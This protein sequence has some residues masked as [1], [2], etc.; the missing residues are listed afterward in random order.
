MKITILYD[1]NCRPGFKASWGFS[2]LVETDKNTIIFDTGW[3][4]NILLHNLGLANVQLEKIDGVVLSH[5]HW[6]HIGGLNHILPLMRKPKVLLL[7]SFSQNLK[8]ELRT[9]TEVLEV[10][11][12]QMIVDGVWTTGE[13]G[14]QIK[15]QSLVVEIP[16]MEGEV[17]GKV[18]ITGCAHP[19]LKSII[20]TAQNV[21]KGDL[22]ALIGGL[23]DSRELGM[24]GKFELLVPCHCTQRKDEIRSKYLNSYEKCAAGDVFKF[25]EID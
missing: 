20:K 12:P 3:D 14:N 2:C 1:N 10:K 4:G 9:K 13:L 15:E 22:K 21:G 25:G 8:Q 17:P 19:D 7:K 16:E 11:D 6:D 5:A 24:M 18:L 23:H